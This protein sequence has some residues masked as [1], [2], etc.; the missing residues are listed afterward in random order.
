MKFPVIIRLLVPLI[1]G[2]VLHFYTEFSF[3]LTFVLALVVGCF[4][5]STPLISKLRGSK[6]AFTVLTF[7]LFFSLGGYLSHIKKSSENENYFM[8]HTEGWSN[9]LV[10]IIEPPE[11][12]ERSV[13]CVVDV[14]KAGEQQVSG[15]SLI[16]LQK[17]DD[18]LNLKYGDL[19][20][21]N[22]RFNQIKSNGNP[23]EFDY[24]RYLRIHDIQ[25]QAYVQ[26][27][28]W[29][30]VG[31][32]ANPVL[33]SIF[34]LREDF[35]EI[36]QNSGMSPKNSMVAN[37]LIL[38]QKEYLDK[39]VLRSYSSAGAMHVLAVSGLHV[40]I[41][42]LILT[43]FL[44]PVKKFKSGKKLFLL[45]VLGGIWFYALITGLSPS[46]MRAGIMFTFIVIGK[47]LQRDTTV[48]QS[49]L[50]SAFIL[51]IVEPYIIF[52]VG[53]QLSYLAVLGIVYL[54][55]KIENLVYIK[56]RILFK[57]WQISS[58]SIAAQIATFP[59]GLYYFHQFPNFFLLS[60]L[61]VIPLAFFILLLGISYLVFHAVPILSE[62][63]FWVFDGL[64]SFL[65]Y[66]V[67]WVEKLP[68]SILWGISIQWYEVFLIYLTILLASVAFINR[69]TKMFLTMLGACVVLLLYN[70]GEKQQLESEK[71][72]CVYNI[73][74]EVAIDLF[75][76]R[77]NIFYC[78]ENLINDE[79][80]L[81]FHVKHNWFY[82]M[83]EEQPD[84]WKNIDS[85]DIVKFGNQELCL[86]D[87]MSYG[88]FADSIPR[89]D[90]FLLHDIQYL[91]Q[92][93][94]DAVMENKS[95]LILAAGTG[96]R[97]KKFLKTEIDSMKIIDLK[98][99]GAF[100]FYF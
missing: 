8:N 90:Y 5:F 24:A 51:I 45:G 93:F 99:D 1:A 9:Y 84:T 89:V 62:I 41:I 54:Q 86:L 34:L 57:A 46:V 83:G 37:A 88:R 32:D 70:L 15:R 35:S 19:L 16:Y 56:N 87:E 42:M 64:I 44:T 53:F 36:F 52:Q 78:T 33:A 63:I 13:K 11:E 48:Y 67:Q 30:K 40:G 59:L 60:N 4:V 26:N 21:F 77:K 38:G 2:V 27:E 47:E 72:V 76:G 82:R 61:L 73:N 20:Y 29:Q 100:E 65:N 28:K 10:K 85:V 17:S 75:Y 25:E 68:Y 97:L 39:D 80:K 22:A 55:P 94:L 31:N 74:D 66:G 23:Y 81:L 6:I 3:T 96:N 69:K 18:A 92:T 91:D 98:E 49:I 50:V 79:D 12:K 58:V 43:T 14:L 95:T 7:C 71:I